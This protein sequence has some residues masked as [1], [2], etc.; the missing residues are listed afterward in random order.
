MFKSIEFDNFRGFKK[1]FIDNFQQYNIFV[2]N[3]NCGKTSIL[4]GIFLL[5]NPANLRLPI[6]INYFRSI[7]SFNETFWKVYFNDLDQNSQI[8]LKGLF[9]N[10]E[11]TRTLTIRPNV[12]SSLDSAG[13]KTFEKD[14]LPLEQSYSGNREKINGLKLRYRYKRGSCKKW[15]TIDASLITQ[16]SGLKMERPTDYSECREGVYN[17]PGLSL[18]DIAP[19]LDQLQVAKRKDVLVKVLKEIEPSLIDLSLGSDNVVYCD[20]GLSRLVP[21][22]IL[23]D[24]FCRILSIVLSISTSNGGVVLIDELEDGLHYSSLKVVWEAIIAAAKEYNAQ[25]FITT[26]SFECI[27]ALIEVIERKKVRKGAFRLFRIEKGEH[28]TDIV[29]FDYKSLK[30]AVESN[31]EVR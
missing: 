22:N 23:G 9:A 14:V 17:N 21:I 8:V 20:I 31:W 27:A 12:G 11:E 28:A 26:H 10:P 25:L 30:A 7:S 19:R 4:E 6:N 18:S 16:E 2:G 29:K 24:G 1:L 15:K 3:N 13:D 5:T